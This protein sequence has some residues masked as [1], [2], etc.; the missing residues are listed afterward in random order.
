[1]EFEY[2]LVAYKYLEGG[3]YGMGKTQLQF[4]RSSTLNSPIEFKHMVALT[5]ET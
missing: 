5:N 2:W 3:D 4:L 1:M